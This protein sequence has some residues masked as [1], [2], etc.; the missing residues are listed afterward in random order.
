MDVKTASKTARQKKG[1][2]QKCV[3]SRIKVG[4]APSEQKKQ[5]KAPS[6]NI[7]KETRE[8][9]DEKH[10]TQPK[11]AA[12]PCKA[13]RHEGWASFQPRSVTE[14]EDVNRLCAWGNLARGSSEKI[15]PVRNL[16]N[17]PALKKTRA[18][19]TRNDSED[20]HVERKA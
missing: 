15:A 16:G 20:H 12:P 9:K 6:S 10:K 17:C 18:D 13:T 5:Q 19:T 1:D 4:T 3:R 7:R 2:I 8:A 14:S 11:P